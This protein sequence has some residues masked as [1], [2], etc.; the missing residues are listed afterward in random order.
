MHL[1]ENTDHIKLPRK[2][3]FKKEILIDGHKQKDYKFKPHN[4]FKVKKVYSPSTFVTLLLM[5]A[6]IMIS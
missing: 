2:P 1:M 4:Q 6:C 5:H 3:K